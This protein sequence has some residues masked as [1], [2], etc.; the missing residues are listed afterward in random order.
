MA[1]L[2]EEVETIFENLFI[3]LDDRKAMFFEKHF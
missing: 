1:T 2:M 3:Y